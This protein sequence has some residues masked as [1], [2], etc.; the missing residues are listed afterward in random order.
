MGRRV[1]EPGWVEAE[2]QV[3]LLPEPIRIAVLEW[4]IRPDGPQA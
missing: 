3:L 2:P 1:K 4:A